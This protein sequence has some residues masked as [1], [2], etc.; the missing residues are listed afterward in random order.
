MEEIV[1]LQGATPSIC[2]Q[3]KI[4]ELLMVII[5]KFLLPKLLLLIILRSSHGKFPRP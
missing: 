5:L 4:G 3:L 2:Y 1:M